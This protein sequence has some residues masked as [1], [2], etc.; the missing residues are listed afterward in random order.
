MARYFTVAEAMRILPEV[1]RHLRDA[2]FAFHEHRTADE[3]FSAL[4]KRI[5]MLGGS[6]LDRE[7]VNRMVARK[8]ASATVLRQELEAISDLGVQVKDLE[9]GLIDFP[10][11]YNGEEVLLCWRFGEE[12][13][14]HWHGVSEGFRGRKPIDK[15]FLASHRGEDEP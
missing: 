12:K 5:L 6:S 2:L 7:K 8:A 15:E 14:E 4:Q 10:T 3:E 9:I 13:I 11:L 1:E